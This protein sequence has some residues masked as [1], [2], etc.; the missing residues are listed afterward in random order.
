ME[1]QARADVSSVAA[2]GR[3]DDGRIR[4]QERSEHHVE[5]RAHARLLSDHEC[6][7]G[8]RRSKTKV[9][10]SNRQCLLNSLA[11]AL[12]Q[13]LSTPPSTPSFPS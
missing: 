9:V 3:A 12:F 2:Q 13:C 10:C 4:E 7:A 11:L 1:H 5:N 6:S 8:R